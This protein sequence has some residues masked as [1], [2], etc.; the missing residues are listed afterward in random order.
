MNFEI[1]KLTET[2]KPSFKKHFKVVIKKGTL[3]S[4]CKR[5]FEIEM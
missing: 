5:N 4:K 2:L 3:K 1:K